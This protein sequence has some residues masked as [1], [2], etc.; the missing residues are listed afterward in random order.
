M[1]VSA[2]ECQPVAAGAPWRKNAK[3]KR[4]AAIAVIGE[5]K[6][7]RGAVIVATAGPW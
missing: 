5:E 1:I 6:G 2:S 7:D 3:P 4:I